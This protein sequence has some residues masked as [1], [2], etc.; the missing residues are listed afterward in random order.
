MKTSRGISRRTAFTM[1]F[2]L[3]WSVSAAGRA[4]ASQL[5]ASVKAYDLIK[6]YEGFGGRAELTAY[7]CPAGRPTVGWGHTKNVRLGDAVTLAQAE[8]FLCEDVAEAERVVLRVIT[9]SCLNQGMFDALVSF[10]FNLG[11]GNLLDS[12]LRTYLNA[13]D[14]PRAASQFQRWVYANQVIQNGL[15]ARRAEERALFLS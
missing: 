2:G 7:L 3:I 15:I 5:V 4:R 14:V 13:G 10:V 8:E 9:F 11:E 6:K 1:V 12:D